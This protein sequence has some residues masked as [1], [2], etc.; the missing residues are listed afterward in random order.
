M[1]S[2]IA[3]LETSQS[4]VGM[5]CGS[6]VIMRCGPVVVLRVV[7]IAVGVRVQHRRPTERRNQRRDEQ[8]R[9]DAVHT[10]SL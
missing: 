4:I 5:A 6:V 10:P 8:Q 9:Q 7:V 1:P 3:P 2:W